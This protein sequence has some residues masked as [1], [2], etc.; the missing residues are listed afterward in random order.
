MN[1]AQHETNVD[2]PARPETTIRVGNRRAQV[3]RTGRVL[4]G[5]IQ[6]RKLAGHRIG[7]I[8]QTHFSLERAFAHLLLHLCEIVLRN[9]EVG[10]DWIDS[11]D[12]QK[13][14]T[15]AGGTAGR[16]PCATA[17]AARVDDVADVRQTLPRAAI[18]RRANI[19]IT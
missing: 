13:R 10:I 16:T 7:P 12:Y 4:H 3:D 5:V 1:R 17:G 6:K 9:C 8:W 14:I 18:D 15:V 2:E 11:F 19:T